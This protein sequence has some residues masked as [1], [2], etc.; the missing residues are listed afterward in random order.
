MYPDQDQEQ[1]MNQH[2]NCKYYILVPKPSVFPLKHIPKRM[3]PLK[4]PRFDQILTAS[5][6]FLSD[7]VDP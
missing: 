3:Q 5:H 2:I 6:A 4:I 1:Q 7:A